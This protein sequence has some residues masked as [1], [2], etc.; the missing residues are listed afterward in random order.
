MGIMSKLA[1]W[2]KDDDFNFDE[3]SGDLPKSSPDMPD[4]GGD[5]ELPTEPNMPSLESGDTPSLPGM[6]KDDLALPKTNAPDPTMEKLQPP[7]AELANPYAEQQAPIHPQ[8]QAPPPQP[9]AHESS[10]L[11]EKNM[12][13]ISA[14]LDMLK[15]SIEGL[16]QKVDTLTRLAT[17]DHSDTQHYTRKDW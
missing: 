3:P 16:N 6:P 4:L 14:K 11:N 13:V 8:M 5:K 12:E 10:E 15:V 1:F 17:K 2:K 9:V 7:K